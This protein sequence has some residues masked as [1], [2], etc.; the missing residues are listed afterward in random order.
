[1]ERKNIHGGNIYKFA[2]AKGIVPSSVVDFSANINPL[3]MSAVA[4]EALIAGVDGCIH[5]PDPGEESLRRVA[6]NVF[7]VSA[8][9]IYFGNG[10][11]ELLYALT[12]L[13]T[14]RKAYVPEPGFSEYR[15]AAGTAGLTVVGYAM[16]KESCKQ[17][18][19]FTPDYEYLEKQ[20]TE[21]REPVIVFLGNPNNPDGSLVQP[22]EVLRLAKAATKTNSLI[23]VDES[24][25]EFTDS[26]TS[27][28]SYITTQPQLVVLHSLTKFYAIP[29]L[30][31]GMLFYGGRAHRDELTSYI[32]AWS[33]NHLAQCYG[34]AALLDTRYQE[35][36][37]TTVMTEK[38]YLHDAFNAFPFIKTS[39]PSVNF[40]LCR[41]LPTTPPIY[42]IIEY[43]ADKAV[44]IRDCSTYEGLGTGWFRVAVKDRDANNLLIH[45]IKEFAYEHDLFS[46]T[47]TD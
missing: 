2:A 43:L 16:K 23:M 31:L 30:R 47:W 25:I 17:G 26:S 45:Y 15:E 38:E 34:Q 4:K 12:R 14:L 27:M 18:Y 36:S 44:L 13:H 32:P 37:R 19:R 7:G 41:W 20:L 46:T 40:M 3:G 5:Y 42:D 22:E 33:V 39:H 1:M 9:M 6:A 24:F 28:R 10:A 29:G 21:E 8:D 35:L 11:A